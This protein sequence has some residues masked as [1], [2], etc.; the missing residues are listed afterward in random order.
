MWNED[1]QNR[2]TREAEMSLINIIIPSKN[3]AGNISELVKRINASLSYNHEI[4]VVDDSTDDTAKIAKKLGCVVVKGRGLGLAQAVIDGI[5]SSNGEYIIILD[6]DL[7]HPPELLPKIVEQ[8]KIHDLVVVSKHIDDS[9]SE[10]SLWRKVQ[11]N[12]GCFAAKIL[13]PVS[14][15][16]TG[17]FGI[18]RECLEGVDLDGIGFKI[19]LEIFCKANW[20]SHCEIPMQFARRNAGVSKGTAQSLQKHLWKLYKSSLKHRIELPKG[21]DEW[22]VFYEG[23]SWQKKWKQ[24][25]A[26]ILQQI[27]NE[28][29]PKRTL[30]LGCGSSPN[31]NYLSGE[32]VGM[33]TRADVLAFM[34]KHSDA[35]F[36]YGNVLDI[37]FYDSTYDYVMCIEVIEHLHGDEAD[38]AISEIARVLEPDGYA[39]IATP[40]YSSITWN[41]IE[42]AQKLLQPGHWTSDHYT[43]FNRD[44][45]TALCQ[46]YGLVELRY[47]GIMGNSDMVITFKKGG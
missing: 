23:N 31:I 38:K 5:N 14:D 11:S 36:A 6:C 9:N 15:P 4:I 19:G 17:Y 46:K 44:S 43:H 12:L 7:Q 1:V 34:R 30:D 26:T 20:A 18:R 25:I 45:L 2:L 35:H 39:T 13:V 47:D 32:R 28:I 8:L 21:C 33:D 40:N 29:K 22:N 24:S 41:L 10:L 3:E 42:N 27:S 16:M 37:P